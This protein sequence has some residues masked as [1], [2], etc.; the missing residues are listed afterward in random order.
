MTQP[1][2]LLGRLA[3]QLSETDQ[4]IARQKPFG[5]CAGATRY[6]A[7]SPKRVEEVDLVQEIDGP[8]RERIFG[9][10]AHRRAVH[11]SDPSR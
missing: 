6:C 2:G 1:Q 10:V 7:S 9:C 8:A 5:N 11:R 4:E 3:L